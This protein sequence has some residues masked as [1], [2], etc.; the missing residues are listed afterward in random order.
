MYKISREGN[1]AYKKF[2]AR[3]HLSCS[4]NSKEA[5][6]AGVKSAKGITVRNEV[7]EVCVL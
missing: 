7:K 1:T 5:H 6:V 4:R 2:K 3:E